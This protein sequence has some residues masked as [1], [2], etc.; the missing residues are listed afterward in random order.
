MT[1]AAS[2]GLQA[3]VYAQ[4]NA[5]VPLTDLVGTAIYDALPSG[6]LPQIY[7]ALGAGEARDKSDMTGRG[8]EHDFTVSV[9][10]DAA[11]FSAAKAV[12]AVICDA[13]IDADLTLT[14]GTLVGLWFRQAKARRTGTAERRQ[15]DLLFRARTD[16]GEV[17]PPP[18]P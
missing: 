13:L 2:A 6:T 12:A 5:H 4:L 17:A 11:G 7:V 8:A 16:D 9:V 18:G 14:R 3:A 15:V 1:Y 10:S